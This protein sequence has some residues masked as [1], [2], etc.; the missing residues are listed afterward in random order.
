[1]GLF[2]SIE[3][4]AMSKVAGSNPEA[5]AILQMVQSHPG[6][7]NG[8]VQSFHDNGMSGL[9]N[10]WTGTGANQA[11]SPEQ[12][13]QVLG[14]DKVQA[15]AQKLGVSPEAA[16]STLAQLL[17]GII[18]KLSPNGAVPNQSNVME[19]GE[20]LLSSFLGQAGAKTGTNS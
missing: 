3:N 14:S 13:Q 19:I 7:L 11:A 4:M 10:S 8:L 9:V 15:I 6:G 17:P 12:I 20:G 5:A 1:M 2:D 16:S 18:D